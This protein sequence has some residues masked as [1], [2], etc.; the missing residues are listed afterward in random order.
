MPARGEIVLAR[1]PFTDGSGTKLRP[2]LVLAAVPGAH[3]D[4]LVL[5]ISS[6]LRIA[7]PGLDLV[8]DR[9]HAAFLATG[10]KVPSVFRIGKLAII[11]SNLIVGPLGQL[12]G[13]SYALIVSR[14]IALVEGKV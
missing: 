11:S 10:L 9:H 13:P 5:F 6:Q 3:D 4:F 7:T 8:L 14:L 12:D 1:F 2:V